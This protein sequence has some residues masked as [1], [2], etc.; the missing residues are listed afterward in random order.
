M[1]LQLG[2]CELTYTYSVN[3]GPTPKS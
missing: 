2:S 1:N 3:P